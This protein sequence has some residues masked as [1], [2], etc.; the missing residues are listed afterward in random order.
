MLL[1]VAAESR[2][3]EG[4][5]KKGAASE[6]RAFCTEQDWGPYPWRAFIRGFF[7]LMT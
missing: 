3:K 5:T 1:G 7:L 2:R 4:Q 6:G